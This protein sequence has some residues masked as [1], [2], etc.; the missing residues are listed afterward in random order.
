M[1]RRYHSKSRLGCSNCK[2][3]RIKCDETKPACDRCKSACLDCVYACPP[4]SPGESSTP[5][6]AATIL[7]EQGGTDANH[8]PAFI[9]NDHQISNG[10]I[11]S[12]REQPQR[13]GSG[14]AASSSLSP[15]N[16]R[17]MEL[18]AHF[19]AH[20]SLILGPA[21]TST[22]M[23]LATTLSTPYLINQVLALA[24]LHLSH[25]V[26]AKSKAYAL[27]A[28]SLQ[29][30]SLS[31]FADS[32][33]SVSRENCIPMLLFAALLGIYT[34][35]DAVLSF[36]GGVSKFLDDYIRYLDVH[37]GA[38]AVVEPFW[39]FLDQTDLA[40]FLNIASRSGSTA[41]HPDV[42]AVCSNLATVVER[43]PLDA[44]AAMAC[45]EA[46]EHLRAILDNIWQAQTNPHAHA[47]SAY[48]TIYSWPILLSAKFTALLAKR[49]PQALVILAHYA[50][51]LHER[52]E[53]WVVGD[54]GSWLIKGISGV[55]GKE[56]EEW[57][58]WPNNALL[59]APTHGKTVFLKTENGDGV[60]Q[61]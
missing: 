17:H 59:H 9:T 51:V 37:R 52:R 19:I 20:T 11:L 12:S 23:A 33:V 42:A 4:V 5:S 44:D 38:R 26:P 6:I 8:N 3:R 40:P 32:N 61:L 31:S 2:K 34:L 7:S 54:A 1:S 43:V 60:G 15:V 29:A 56:W 13:N 24:S 30:D 28:A 16:M 57:L 46:I 36:Q 58:I 18:L 41:S 55:L 39:E 14:P 50:V 49:V 27:E 25:L 22:R 10:K 48:N 35:A 47:G 45:R 21:H 53:V